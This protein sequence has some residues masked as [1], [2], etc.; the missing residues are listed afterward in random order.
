M[1][2]DLTAP[3]ELLITEEQVLMEKIKTCEACVFAV[4]DAVVQNGNSFH[5]ITTEEILT[6]IHNMGNDFQTE[7]LHLR[8]EKSILASSASHIDTRC[9]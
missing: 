7:L 5:A 8:L 4:L 1:D 3:Y 6:V 9:I 2:S